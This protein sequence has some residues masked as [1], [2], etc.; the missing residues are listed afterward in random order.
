MK[1]C[2]PLSLTIDC[3]LFASS[4]RTKFDDSVVFTTRSPASMAAGSSVAQYFPSRYSRTKT[5]T[6]APTLT[7]RTRSLR[8]TFPAKTVVDCWSRSSGAGIGSP[9]QRDGVLDPVEGLQL[10]TAGGVDQGDAHGLLAGFLGDHHGHGV[11]LDPL[12][13]A[14]GDL[15]VHLPRGVLEPVRGAH[16]AGDD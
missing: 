2:L 8:T 12:R 4:G 15:E 16:G 7:L 1:V 11:G 5:G 10:G 13:I 3:A 9:S 14:P 6:F